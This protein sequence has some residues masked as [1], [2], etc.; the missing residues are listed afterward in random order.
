MVVTDNIYNLYKPLRNYLKQF[1]LIDS[2][3]VI[4][5]YLQYM[6]FNINLPEDI[7]TDNSFL[8]A[9]SKYE[10]GVYEWRLETLVKEIIINA[11]TTTLS[12]TFRDWRYF[13]NALIKLCDLENNINI[14]YKN[15]FEQQILIELFRSSHRQF[16]WNTHPNTILLNRYYKVFSHP[17]IDFI[18]QKHTGLTTKE[19][20]IIG[21]ALTGAYL[22]YFSLSYPPE[23]QILGITQ[24]KIDKFLKHFSTD[25]ESIKKQITNLQSY[26]YDYAYTLNPLSI[27]PI[28]RTKIYGKDSIIAPVPTLLFKRFTEGIYYE[29]CNDSNFD[30]PFGRSFQSYIGEVIDKSNTTEK[31]QCIK[32][33]EYYIGRNRKDT[34]DWFVFDDTANLFIECKTKRLKVAS[35][36]KLEDMTVLD[37][38]LDLMA[39]FI[40]QVYKTIV[41][42]K[43]DFYLDNKNNN[44]TCFPLILTLEDWYVFG[45]KIIID[46]I[47]EKVKNKLIE[48]QIDLKITLEEPYTICSSAEFNKLMQI[49]NYID[50]KK[51]MSE[52]TTNEHRL[53]P[54]SS[55]MHKYYPKE[56][57]V[58]IDLFADEYKE[59]HSVIS[60]S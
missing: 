22:D 47:D 24:E 40:V 7:H 16:P 50:I 39:D 5:A 26:D 20:Y 51:F 18:I 48:K 9:K 55:F 46:T 34:I 57:S 56:S 54:L 21:L 4:R 10:R 3:A 38:D 58:V 2:L 31:Y 1:S 52:K 8:Q 25:M 30:I 15:V 12:K 32:E 60:R 44:K 53:W 28:I 23:L 33:S 49:I 45:D 29:I 35:K 41:D 59:I 17:K 19:L 14:H 13:S 43:N 37:K 6:Q 36:N 11:E 42:Y 27:T